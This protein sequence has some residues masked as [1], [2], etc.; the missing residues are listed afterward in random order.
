MTWNKKHSR[1]LILIIVL[2]ALIIGFTVRTLYRNTVCDQVKIVLLDSTDIRFVDQNYI[3]DFISQKIDYKVVGNK[4]KNINLDEIE[5]KLDSIPYIKDAQVYRDK[6]KFLYIKISQY[7]PIAQVFDKNNKSFY[8]G[9]QGYIIPLSQKFAYYVPIFNGNIQHYDSLFYKKQ[10]VNDQRFK[11]GILKE[12]YDFAGLIQND[13]YMY[14]LVDQVY[15]ND[16]SNLVIIPKIGSFKIIFGSVDDYEDK[17]EKLK[18][19]YTIALPRVGWN[20]YSVVNLT[21]RNQIVCTKN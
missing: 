4:F 13:Q 7:R 21:Y 2:V 6:N 5:R 14:M 19:F 15:V 18:S 3:I 17:I 20:K 10:N 8:L 9:E 12:I 16:S 1:I 11:N